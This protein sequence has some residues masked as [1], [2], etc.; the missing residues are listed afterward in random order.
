MLVPVLH[1]S[2]NNEQTSPPLRHQPV[3]F[4]KEG[5]SGSKNGKTKKPRQKAETYHRTVETYDNFLGGQDWSVCDKNCG[6]CGRCY[7]QVDN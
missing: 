2:T 1:L 3:T 7:D 4:V 6:W 5:M